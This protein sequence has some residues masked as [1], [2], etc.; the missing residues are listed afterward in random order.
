[1]NDMISRHWKWESED[2]P[3]WI[4]DVM[5][6]RNVITWT[7]IVIGFANVKDLVVVMR[8]FDSM[9]ERSVVW[10]LGERQ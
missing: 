6:E 10:D 5:L 3:Q 9:L 1:M 4:F 7:A 8:Y 2:Q